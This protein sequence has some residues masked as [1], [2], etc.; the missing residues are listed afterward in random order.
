[1]DL[2]PLTLVLGGARSG[3]SAYAEFLIEG[4]AANPVYLATAEAGD[5]EMAT[6]IRAH[7]ERRGSRWRT[8]EEPLA[9]AAALAR[10]AVPGNA[11]LVDCLTLWLSNL[12]ALGRDID[13]EAAVLLDALARLDAP[14]V[15]VSNQ[16]G[17]GIV[18]AN[19]PARRFRDHAGL[20]HQDIA[21]LAG[22]VVLVTAGLPLVLKDGRNGPS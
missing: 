17:E 6:R 19:E 9:L 12:M 1:M 16:V 22:R 5:D 7:R 13:A 18:P 8:V 11:V 20:L 4:C 21:H 2:P 15:L 14:V 10:E 3:K